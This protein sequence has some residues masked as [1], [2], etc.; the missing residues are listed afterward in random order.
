MLEVADA[1]RAHAAETA[2]LNGV[3]L[4]GARFGAR[5]AIFRPERR[6]CLGGEVTVD[7]AGT[8]KV[9]VCDLEPGREYVVGGQVTAFATGAGVIY[10]TVTIPGA[11]ATLTVQA[12]GAVAQR[13]DVPRNLKLM[14]QG[15]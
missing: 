8:Y 6:R 4:V 1:G 9:L 14:P 10:A 13:P 2:L 11:G 12:T 15:N 3:G 5:I 7:R